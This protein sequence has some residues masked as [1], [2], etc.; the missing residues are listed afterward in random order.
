[1]AIAVAKLYWIRML[2]QELKVPLV[3]TLCLWVDNINALFLSP[4]ILSFMPAQ[5]T[6]KWI[7]TSLERKFL[8]RIFLLDTFSLM[9]NHP[10]FSPKVYLRPNFFSYETSWWSFLYPSTWGGILTVESLANQTW[11][12]PAYSKNS[13]HAPSCHCHAP[14]CHCHA[15]LFYTNSLSRSFKSPMS[16]ILLYF[17]LL[18]SNINILTCKS[19]PLCIVQKY[20]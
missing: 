2:F 4:L 6:L 10:T 9:F 16:P 5:S 14:S 20:K 15:R 18:S 3:H 8:I 13:S 1:M 19:H 17:N 7:I 11:L 12:L